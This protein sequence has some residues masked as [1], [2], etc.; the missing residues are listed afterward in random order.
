MVAHINN[1]FIMGGG[2]GGGVGEGSKDRLSQLSLN[3]HQTSKQ[4]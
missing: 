2:G 4:L 3:R 1:K